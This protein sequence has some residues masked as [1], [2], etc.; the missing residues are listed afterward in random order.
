MIWISVIYSNITY[1]NL[2]LY[3]KDEAIPGTLVRGAWVEENLRHTVLL[4]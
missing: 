2:T 3:T 1:T 4:L